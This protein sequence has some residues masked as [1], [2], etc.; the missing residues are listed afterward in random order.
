MIK[1]HV[2]NFQIS[3]IILAFI[4]NTLF[5]SLADLALVQEKYYI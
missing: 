5:I 3:M 1:L 2:I 4:L